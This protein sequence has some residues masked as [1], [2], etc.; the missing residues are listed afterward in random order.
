MQIP[1]IGENVSEA[2]IVEAAPRREKSSWR[3][4]DMTGARSI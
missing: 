2:R 4:G 1:D 3:P